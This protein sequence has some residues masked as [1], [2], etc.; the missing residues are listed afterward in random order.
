MPSEEVI[1]EAMVV[2]WSRDAADD[3]EIDVRVGDVI[4]DVE[5]VE[6]GWAVGRNERTGARGLIP[7]NYME[8]RL[9]PAVELL[10]AQF[11]FPGKEEGEIS[12]VDGDIISN[13]FV[14][15]KGWMTGKNERTGDSGL[16]PSNYVEYVKVPSIAS[17]LEKET[18]DGDE[19]EKNM[20]YPDV[21]IDK[22]TMR[23]QS[24]IHSSAHSIFGEEITRELS[25]R[26]IT[27]LGNVCE[28]LDAY[29]DRE[30]SKS[31]ISSSISEDHLESEVP[32]SS[33]P[34]HSSPTP[35]S[36]IS[37]ASSNNLIDLIGISREAPST[38]GATEK[39]CLSNVER[40]KRFKFFS[41]KIISK[42]PEHENA[43]EKNTVCIDPNNA[44]AEFCVNQLQETYCDLMGLK[45]RINHASCEWIVAFVELGGLSAL[46]NRLVL[47]SDP[48]EQL[49]SLTN[50]IPLLQICDCFRSVLNSELALRTVLE[51]QSQF[52]YKLVEMIFFQ[53]PL[54]KIKV[55]ELLSAISMYNEKGHESVLSALIKHKV[56]DK[57]DH[58]FSL[59]IQELEVDSI[60]YTSAIWG[61]VNSYLLSTKEALERVHLRTELEKMGIDSVFD[62]LLKVSEPLPKCIENQIE[63]YV[64]SRNKDATVPEA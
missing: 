23:L 33:I 39:I 42:L 46:M 58:P 60:I 49:R 20:E 38:A 50:I 62:R 29:V 56:D 16:F 55:W 59:I 17:F 7:S 27:E 14:V 8:A 9:I 13:A 32:A 25:C 2:Q 26:Q 43:G 18:D 48:A 53:P 5:S 37:L 54:V 30:E 21:E 64:E 3:T 12:L 52:I 40:G 41:N 31:N 63:T 47:Q 24:K 36:P 11:D 1:V 34:S 15:M 28:G 19:K 44:T 10:I 6:E 61:F 22:T 51:K 45:H 4:I 35:K 57:H